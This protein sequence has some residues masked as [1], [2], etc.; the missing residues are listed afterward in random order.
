MKYEVHKRT[1]PRKKVLALAIG[2]VLSAPTFGALAAE[3]EVE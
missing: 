3:A 1:E 2:I